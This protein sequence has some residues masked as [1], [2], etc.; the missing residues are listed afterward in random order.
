MA[1]TT[2]QPSASSVG[3]ANGFAPAST[4]GLV[5]VESRFQT[6]T[7]CPTDINRCAID[8]PIRPV[9]H[10]P[11]FIFYLKSGLLSLMG[12]KDAKILRDQGLIVQNFTGIAG[13]YA[14][15]CVED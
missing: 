2:S 7:S 14:A 15:P 9:P 12:V 4:S 8:D 5:F 10:T 11:I 3:D 13:E 6:P 1:M